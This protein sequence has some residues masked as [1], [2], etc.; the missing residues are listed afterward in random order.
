[1]LKIAKFQLAL[2]CVAM[3]CV[4]GCSRVSSDWKAAQQ[5][6][7]SEAYQEFLHQHPDS[8][9]TGQAQAR[10]KQLA[11]DRDW[12]QAAQADTLDAYQQFLAQHAD[13]KWAQ[14]ARVRI[15]NFQQKAAA[16]PPVATAA[17]MPSPL[18]PGAPGKHQ[19]AAAPPT[20]GKAHHEAQLGAYATKAR[21]ESAWKRLEVKFP[22]QLKGLR[23]NYVPGKYHG[24]SVYRLRVPTRSPAKLCSAL[25]KQS[26]PC[27]PVSG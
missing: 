25:K 22:T 15:E 6:D 14:E 27:V 16:P 18:S 11:E 4:A 20:T 19:A 10:V 8:E 17:P 7:T 1:M 9:F 12:Q 2:L 13:S 3:L 5:A 23:P 26:Q 24:K 21:A